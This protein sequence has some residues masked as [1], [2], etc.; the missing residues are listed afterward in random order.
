MDINGTM[1]EK[2][3]TRVAMVFSVICGSLYIILGLLQMAAGTGKMVMGNGFS[4]PLADILFV[5][6]DIIGSFVLLLIGTVFI[7]GVMEMRSGTY[8]GISYAY[9]GILLALIFALI[10]LLVCT[11]NLLETYL[12]KNEEFAGWTPLSDMRPGIYL[13]ILPL[14]AYIKWKDFLEPVPRN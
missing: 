9:V 10:Y 1:E 4:M 12:L 3:D 6:A 7:Y 8:E 14:V 2:Q 13:A 11:G 5:P